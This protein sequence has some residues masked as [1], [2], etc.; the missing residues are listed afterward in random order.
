MMARTAI[1]LKLSIKTKAAGV[2]LRML[3]PLVRFGLLSPKRATAIV[4]LFVKIEVS[5]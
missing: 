2:V 4:M 3:E 5:Q 1:S